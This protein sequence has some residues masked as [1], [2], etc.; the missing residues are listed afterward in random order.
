[1]EPFYRFWKDDSTLRTGWRDSF[2]LKGQIIKGIAV[3]TTQRQVTSA[4]DQVVIMSQTTSKLGSGER[5]AKPDERR[6]WAQPWSRSR[7]RV[8]L[9]KGKRFNR[10]ITRNSTLGT[11]QKQGMRKVNLSNW[12]KITTKTK[13]SLPKTFGPLHVKPR[14]LYS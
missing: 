4:P 5:K 11:E 3:I 6:S 13:G 9:R 2:K 14:G 7:S 8:L 1:M 12:R 10:N